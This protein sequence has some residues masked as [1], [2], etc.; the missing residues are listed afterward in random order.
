MALTLAPTATVSN[1]LAVGTPPHPLDIPLSGD[2]L[3]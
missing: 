1:S 2:I 3:R